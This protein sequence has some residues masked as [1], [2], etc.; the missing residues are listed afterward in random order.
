MTSVFQDGPINDE[1]SKASDTIRQLEC[2]PK[3]GLLS[4][5][6]GELVCGLVVA[7][8]YYHHVSFWPTQPS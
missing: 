1:T 6:P 7:N 8:K 4:D 3:S 2:K 5:F